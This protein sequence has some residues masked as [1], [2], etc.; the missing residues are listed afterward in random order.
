MLLVVAWEVR[1]RA[2]RIGSSASNTSS[3]L[4]LEFVIVRKAVVVSL[5]NY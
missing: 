1:V 5:L 2:D 3:V 4:L